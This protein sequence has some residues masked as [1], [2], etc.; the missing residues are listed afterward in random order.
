MCDDEATAKE[1]AIKDSREAIEEYTPMTMDSEATIE[2]EDSKVGN[3][4]TKISD[5]ESESATAVS[6]R[7]EEQDTLVKTEKEISETTEE[8]SGSKRR[9]VWC[10]R[11]RPSSCSS[12]RRTH[13]PR[14]LSIPRVRS[15]AAH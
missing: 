3:L 9:T 7:N 15:R 2:T 11:T 14:P 5:T 1:Y 8:L 13:G 4:V 6:L 12:R 10:R